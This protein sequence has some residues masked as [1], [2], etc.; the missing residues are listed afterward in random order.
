MIRARVASFDQALAPFNVTELLDS[1]TPQQLK[2]LKRK[3]K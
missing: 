2:N 3:S 1:L